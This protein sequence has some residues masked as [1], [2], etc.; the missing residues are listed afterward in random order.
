[1]LDECTSQR[2][3]R[4]KEQEQ[5][6]KEEGK[7]KRRLIPEEGSLKHQEGA[8]FSLSIPEKI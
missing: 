7:K 1:M 3:L 8:E 2:R 6:H 4:E 5:V